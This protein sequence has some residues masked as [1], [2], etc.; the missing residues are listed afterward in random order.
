M[1]VKS[2]ADRGRLSLAI[3]HKEIIIDALF[4]LNNLHKELIRSNYERD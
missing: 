2:F 4:A 1:E 3:E